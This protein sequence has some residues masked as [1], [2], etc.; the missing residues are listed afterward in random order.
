MNYW[1]GL[2][3]AVAFDA[4]LIAGCDEVLGPEP[5]PPAS[6]IA[7]IAEPASL[8][9]EQLGELDRRIDSLMMAVGEDP[10]NVDAMEAL[11]TLYADNGWDDRA[12]GPLARALQLDPGRRSL[13]VALD[14]AVEKSGRAKITDDELVRAAQEF[15]EMAESWGHGC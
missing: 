12:I 14:H 6:A 8:S 4:A 3:I 2:L 5:V 9:N 13:W 15:V 11:A 10:T 7:P 1:K